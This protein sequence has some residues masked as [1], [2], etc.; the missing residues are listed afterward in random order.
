MLSLSTAAGFC[1]SFSDGRWVWATFTPDGRTRASGAAGTR[2][3]AA[4]AIVHDICQ[5]CTRVGAVAA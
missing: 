5:A 3:M 2:A 1:L 4:A